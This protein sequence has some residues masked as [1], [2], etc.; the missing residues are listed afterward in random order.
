MIKINAT[1]ILTIF[2][3]ILLV[4]VLSKILWKPMTKFL[5]E[6]AQQI[7]DSL[8]LAEENKQ[9]AI[10]MTAEHD[11]LIREAREKA[12]EITEKTTAQASDESRRIIAEARSQA[13]STVDAAREE[14]QM[15]AEKIKQDL[16]REIAALTVSLAGQVLEQEIT[17]EKHRELIEKGLNVLSS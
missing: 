8:Q 7:R 11:T 2:N 6:R 16:R 15:E 14:I 9:R 3:F 4:G 1:L 17:V 10:E 12:L 13:R 5:E